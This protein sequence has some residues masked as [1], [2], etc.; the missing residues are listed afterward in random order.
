[1][2]KSR[3][4]GSSRGGSSKS[5]SRSA[6]HKEN[7]NLITENKAQKY[8]AGKVM[9]FAVNETIRSGNEVGF[10]FD[11]ATNRLISEV[12]EGTNNS[13]GVGRSDKT[14]RVAKSVY[15]RHRLGHFHTHPED[16]ADLGH[17]ST[18]F[19]ELDY[20]INNVNEMVL[21]V[22]RGQHIRKYTL[23]TLKRKKDDTSRQSKQKSDVKRKQIPY[24]KSPAEFDTFKKVKP[25]SGIPIK[26]S[27]RQEKNIID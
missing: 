20:K 12:R 9:Q 11:T 4:S 14:K 21:A 6:K 27:K 10:M 3:S 17:R 24:D 18:S 16:E 7:F 25:I 1:M 8:P 2:G 5:S 13:I 23:L 19:T 15:H 26:S 22:P